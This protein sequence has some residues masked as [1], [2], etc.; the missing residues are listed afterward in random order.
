MVRRR[1]R[2]RD[3]VLDFEDRYLTDSE[4]D[5]LVNWAINNLGGENDKSNRKSN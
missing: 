5:K 2:S 4:V 1:H 3:A